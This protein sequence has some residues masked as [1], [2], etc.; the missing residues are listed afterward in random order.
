[1]ERLADFVITPAGPADAAGLAQ[2]HVA[3]WRSTYPGLLPQTFLDAMDPRLYARRW[4]R[5]L[6]QTHPAEVTL[7]AER[8]DGVIGYCQGAAAGEEAEVFTLYVVRSAQGRGV[9]RA[10]LTAT[11]RVFRAREAKALRLWVLEGNRGAQGFYTRLGGQPAVRRAASGW[12]GGL[13]EVR[14][15]WPAIDVLAG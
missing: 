6:E 11:A 14:Y 7:A 13:T 5:Q 9:G 10:L 3:A 12:G 8:L 4:R 15:D 2:A 1:M